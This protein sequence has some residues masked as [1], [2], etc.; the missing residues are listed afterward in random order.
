[1]SVPV[2]VP[3]LGES[4]TEATINRW[5]KQPGD[6]VTCDEPLVE[7]STDKVDTEIVAPIAGIVTEFSVAEGDTVVVGA[8]IAVIRSAEAGPN[9]EPSAQSVATTAV[10]ESRV[11]SHTEAGVGGADEA[12]PGDGDVFLSP[13]VRRLVAQHDVDVASLRGTGLGGRIR[14]QDVLAAAEQLGQGISGTSAATDSTAGFV[15]TTAPTVG[16]VTTAPGQVV[17]QVLPETRS[18]APETGIKSRARGRPERL[19]PLRRKLAVRM[20]QSLQ[21]TAQLTTV[22]EVDASRVVA[23]RNKLWDQGHLGGLHLTYLPFFA[24]ACCQ[25]LAHNPKL[26]ASLDGETVTYHDNV[27]LCVAVDTAR[28]LLA[29]VIQ[30]ADQLNP[31]GL[32]RQIADVAARAR[33]DEL[34][35]DELVGGTFTITN[36]GSRGALFDT[37]ILNPPQSA[38]LGVGALVRRPVVLTRADGE[39]TI[40]IRSMAH[41]ALTYD[42]RLV[43]GADAARFLSAVAQVL[44]DDYSTQ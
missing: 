6:T 8:Q 9:G 16:H 4:V 12:G 15:A 30:D 21:S 10:R 26:N 38:I 1:M 22:I 19:S 28:G 17:G 24:A 37:P 5:L 18:A 39:E 27:H 14:K 31:L 41:L 40:G 7:V 43:D 2:V 25:V 33:A 32:A 13:L 11:L 42:H 36:T 35:P 34:R 3:R 44:T 29:P 23:Q 20:M